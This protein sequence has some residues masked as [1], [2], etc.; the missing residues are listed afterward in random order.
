VP[1]YRAT[2]LGYPE[3]WP[4]YRTSS[5]V[6]LCWELEEPKG[7]KGFKIGR[8]RAPRDGWRWP[9]SAPCLRDQPCLEAVPRNSSE[10][11]LHA[12][13]VSKTKAFAHRF[14]SA[15]CR[16]SRGCRWAGERPQ[17][18]L[19]LAHQTLSCT[20]CWGWVCGFSWGASRGDSRARE[21]GQGLA[22]TQRS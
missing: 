1:L 16:L 4:F 5:G 19:A 2:W 11:F 8:C 10:V 9:P 18:H 13:L 14:G 15:L 12:V 7:P 17:Q 22:S 20:P 6:R 3:A 21:P